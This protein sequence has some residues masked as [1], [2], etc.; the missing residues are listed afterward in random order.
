ML[1]VTEVDSKT[2]FLAMQALS[3]LLMAKLVPRVDTLLT[4]ATVIM[5]RLALSSSS[6]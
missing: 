2:V 3:A 1:V 5:Q 6:S 4:P